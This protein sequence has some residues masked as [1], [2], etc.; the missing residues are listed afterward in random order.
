MTIFEAIGSCVI[1][2]GE[3]FC[4]DFGKKKLVMADPVEQEFDSGHY[5]G[6]ENAPRG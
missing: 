5:N 3:K 2:G 6:A 1:F 4:S